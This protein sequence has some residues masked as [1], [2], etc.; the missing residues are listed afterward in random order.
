M[1]ED[2]CVVGGGV[3]L[4]FAN[5]ERGTGLGRALTLSRKTRAGAE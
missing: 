3:V 5:E 4:A 1:T 2:I